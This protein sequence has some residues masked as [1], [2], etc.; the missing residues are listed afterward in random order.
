MSTS[1]RR[2]A[3]ES[4]LAQTTELVEEQRSFPRRWDEGSVTDTLVVML[5]RTETS[6]HTYVIP[7]SEAREEVV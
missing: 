6:E 1:I 4:W 7:Q 5:G 3:L 2:A